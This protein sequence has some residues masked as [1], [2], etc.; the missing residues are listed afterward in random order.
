MI[1]VDEK[2]GLFLNIKTYLK[3][4]SKLFDYS[5][6]DIKEVNTFIENPTYLTRKNDKCIRILI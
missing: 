4:S 5:S 6:K 1:L 3:N 2:I